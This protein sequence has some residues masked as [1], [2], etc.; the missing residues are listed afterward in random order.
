MPKTKLRTQ[1]IAKLRSA[2]VARLTI[3]RDALSV[4]LT[5]PTELAK[6]S[7]S[8]PATRPEAQPRVGA[9]LSAISSAVSPIANSASDNTSSRRASPSRIG[10]FGNRMPATIAEKIPG[11]TL[12]R[13]SQCQE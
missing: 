12:I 11:A 9:S 10:S 4:R 7:A 8:R 5:K 2:K 3:G 6:L 1:P 13:N